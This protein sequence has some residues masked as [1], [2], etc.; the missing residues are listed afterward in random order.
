MSSLWSC[1]LPCSSW[2]EWLWLCDMVRLG[3]DISVL[4]GFMLV[5]VWGLISC[6]EV[7]VVN[8]CIEKQVEM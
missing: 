1:G 2:Q 5:V 6:C 4:K 7:I 3:R 8:V